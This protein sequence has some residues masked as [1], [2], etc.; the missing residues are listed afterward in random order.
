MS[1]TTHL[2]L[3]STLSPSPLLFLWRNLKKYPWD[4]AKAL[5]AVILTSA[6]ILGVGYGLRTLV[7]KGFTAENSE[8]LNT[9]A[10]FLVGLALTLAFSAYLR[11]STT[12]WLGEKII[13]DLRQK[14]FSHTMSLTIETFERNRLGDLLSRLNTDCDQIRTFI[15]GSAAVALRTLLQLIGGTTLLIISS[16]QLTLYVFAIIPFVI[17]PISLFGKRV[18]TLTHEAQALD[19]EALSFA[20]ERINALTMIK[21]FTAESYA[22][23]VFAKLQKKKLSLVKRRTH[24][25]SLLISLVI[26]LIFSAIAGILWIGAHEVIA[27]RLT[28]G[29]L[30]SFVFYAIVVAGSMNSFAEIISNFNLTLGATTRLTELLDK[31]TELLSPQEKAALSNRLP[32]T[33]ETFQSLDFKDITFTYPARPDAEVLNNISFT[34]H[35]GQ[36][37]ALVGPSGVGKSTL[38]KLL[39]RFYQ[40]NQGEILLNN[41]PLKNYNLEDI[42]NLFTLVPQDP[43]I[44][45]TSIINNIA[46]GNPHATREEILK[47]ARQ[48]H[49]DEFATKFPQGYE[50]ELG[51]KGV[52]LSGGQKQ[53]VALARAILKNAPIFLLDEATN[54]LDSQ[55]E[56]RI[57]DAL[58]AILKDKSALIIAHR[59][60]TVKEADQII[61]LSEKTIDAVGTHTQLMKRS[62]LYKTLAKQ[63]FLDL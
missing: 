61:V 9:S 59:L 40:P 6:A 33:S 60:S 56:Q 5:L 18:K 24:Y 44:F 1:Q 25:R 20:E 38:F 11:T 27:D 48:A 57:Q 17:I 32:W 46:L 39:L 49:I 62:P 36:K 47:A 12:A 22:N 26:A 58:H 43:V 15:S 37:I 31:P 19:G 50:T 30:S 51:E 8:L 34:F 35:K 3:Q 14:V 45:N 42:R 2:P 23:A 52:R 41:T 53:R 29:Q 63:Q 10:L 16:P 7:D 13:N 21:S 28:A 55:S 54:A 4:I